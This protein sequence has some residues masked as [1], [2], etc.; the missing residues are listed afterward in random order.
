MIYQLISHFS[1]IS[2]AKG[3]IESLEELV[4][5]FSEEYV[6]DENA[7]DALIDS[8]IEYLQTLKSN[9]VKK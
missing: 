9:Q 3:F 2:S 8:L 7:K 5:T 4:E 1:D 6:K